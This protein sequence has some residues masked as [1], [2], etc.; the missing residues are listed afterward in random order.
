MS[1]GWNTIDSD[2][3]VFSELCRKLGIRGVQFEDLYAI[4]EH[5]LRALNLAVYGVVFLF[6]YTDLDRLPNPVAGHFDDDEGIFFAQQTIPNACATQA[7]LNVLLNKVDAVDVGP[8]LLEFREFV[9][10]FPL[11]LKGETIT[12]SDLIRNVHNLFLLPNPFYDDLE[13]PENVGSDDDGLFHFVG[14]LRC[15]DK[16]V[17]LDGLK[18]APIVHGACGSDDEFLAQLPTVLQLRIAAY[19]AAEMRFSLMAITQDRLEVLRA[20]GAGDDDE[21]VVQELALREQQRQE[22]ELRQ[23]TWIGLWLDVAKGMAKYLTQE[24]WQ[25]MVRECRVASAQRQLRRLEQ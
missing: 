11:E 17:E 13:R 14:F 9:L 25:A 6:K 19:A 1:Q 16:L 4:D 8:E 10:Q 5:S 22:N 24:E 23:R 20:L 12:N 3:L 21:L 15:K 2:A 7:V 18:R